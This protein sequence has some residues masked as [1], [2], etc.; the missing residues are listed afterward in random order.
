VN[1]PVT[2]TEDLTDQVQ[3]AWAEA[4]DIEVEAVPMDVNFFETG[5]NSLLLLLLAERLGELTARELTVGELFQHSTVRA[6]SAFLATPEPALP[7]TR[8]GATNRRDLLR[9]VEGTR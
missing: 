1:E 8:F 6:Q 3:R 7:S 4:L 9:R 5:G 2:V